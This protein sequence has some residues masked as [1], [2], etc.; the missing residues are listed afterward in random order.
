MSV[1]TYSR[2]YLVVEQ[3]MHKQLRSRLE[4]STDAQLS[5]R[6]KNT[7]QERALYGYFRNPCMFVWHEIQTEV[8]AEW[9]GT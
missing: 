1:W 8:E 4:L 9:Y 6:V 2:V 5:L 7:A 3:Q